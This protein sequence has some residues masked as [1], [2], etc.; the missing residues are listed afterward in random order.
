V[1]FVLIPGPYPKERGDWNGY[2]TGIALSIFRPH[3][4]PLSKGE[5]SVDGYG[6]GITLIY[7]Y[8]LSSPPTLSKGEGRL[9]R[10]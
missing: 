4:Q 9:E 5:G 8:V 1:C 2:S 10:V 7:M 6:A 3:P